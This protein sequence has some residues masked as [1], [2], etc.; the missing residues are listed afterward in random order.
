MIK[1]LLCIILLLPL[2]AC[3]AH[4]YRADGDRVTLFLRIPEAKKVVLYGS[5]DGFAAHPATYTSGTWEVRL[6]LDKPFTYFY[7]VNDELFL[8]DCPAREK[9]DFGSENCIFDPHR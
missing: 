6:P 3:S 7:R 2:S 1:G 5:M 8:P 4:H 9:D